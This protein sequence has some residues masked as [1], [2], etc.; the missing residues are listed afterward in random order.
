MEA[1][2]L[3]KETFLDLMNLLRQSFNATLTSTTQHKVP[4]EDNHSMETVTPHQTCI[5]ST[6]D[7]HINQPMVTLTI[8]MLLL[9]PLT[10]HLNT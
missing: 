1:L 2:K 7:Q 5:V 3:A 6:Q 9:K 8:V 4:P 10:S